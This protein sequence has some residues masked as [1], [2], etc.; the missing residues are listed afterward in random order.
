MAKKRVTSDPPPNQPPA[1]PKRSPDPKP[2]KATKPAKRA[3]LAKAPKQPR[4]SKEERE[5][6]RL[7]RETLEV[8]G[9]EVFDLHE[10]S[11]WVMDQKG[12]LPPLYGGDF[13]DEDTEL[14]PIWG[15]RNEDVGDPQPDIGAVFLRSI[16]FVEPNLDLQEIRESLELDN[17][18]PVKDILKTIS[19]ASGKPIDGAAELENLQ[20]FLMLAGAQ[21]EPAAGYTRDGFVK[22]MM[23]GRPCAVFPVIPTSG[24]GDD[25]EYL[26]DKFEDIRGIAIYEESPQLLEAAVWHYRLQ[27]AFEQAKQDILA[28]DAKIDDELL[29]SDVYNLVALYDDIVM[30]GFRFY[31]TTSVLS[32]RQSQL[33]VMREDN[34][35]LLIPMPLKPE[36]EPVEVYAKIRREVFNDELE[37]IRFQAET[38]QEIWPNIRA[39]TYFCIRPRTGRMIKTK[40][41]LLD[42]DGYDVNAVEEWTVAE[43]LP[44][45][46]QRVHYRCLYE[47]L[48]ILGEIDTFAVIG[49][50]GDEE[51]ADFPDLPEIDL[52]AFIP[53]PSSKKKKSS[54]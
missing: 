4:M 39:H 15:I 7:Q 22:A 14:I 28:A 23:D 26:W 38:L 19:E 20:V 16:P 10:V 2:P 31:G 51:E 41:E 21:I 24:S 1:T 52:D 11:L 43:T 13:L 5:E 44:E 50:G 48:S 53:P 32:E 47:M 18:W 17:D 49:Q 37:S 12:I 34:G 29:A 9:L 25:L 35:D 30:H 45:L 27:L 42:V 33:D 54:R 36:V 40:D 8:L 3:A 46:Y 6:R